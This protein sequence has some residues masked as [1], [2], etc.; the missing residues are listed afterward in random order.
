MSANKT[1]PDQEV[2]NKFRE[3]RKKMIEAAGILRERGYDISYENGSAPRWP[4][5]SIKILKKV[6]VSL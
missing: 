4:D 6:E 3:F 5:Y 1:L 2:A